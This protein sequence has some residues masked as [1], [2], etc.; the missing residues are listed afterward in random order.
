MTKESGGFFRKVAKFVANPTTDWA[1]LD[2]A[3]TSPGESEFAKSEIKAMIE[4]KRR[5]DF[6][7]KRE[8]D[9]LRKI[10]REGLT[11]DAALALGSPSNLDPESSPHAGARSDMAVKAKIDAIEQQMVG[12]VT[13]QPV[14]TP[15]ARPGTQSIRL[16]DMPTQ[17]DAV[18]S[19]ATLPF[20][21][22]PAPQVS[23]AVLDAAREALPG[24]HARAMQPPT[25]DATTDVVEVMH[26]PEL[27]E[28]VIAFANA[29]FDQ[30]ERDLMALVQPG[31]PRHDHLDT[32]MVLFDLYRALDLPQKFEQLAVSFVQKFGVSPPQWYSLP[33]KVSQFLNQSQSGAAPAGDDPAAPPPDDVIAREGWLAPTVLDADAMA[34]LRIACLQLPRPWTMSWEAVEDIRP[35]GAAL[36]AQAMNQWAVDG[37]ALVWH[38]AELLLERLAEL[39]PTGSRDADPAYWMLKL[40]ILRLTNRP[41]LFDEVAIDYCVTY[42]LSPPSWE[43]SLARVLV[44]EDTVSA[45]TRPLSHVSEVTTSFVESQMLDDVE[46]VQVA[47]LNLSGQLLG[48]IGDTL[49]RLDDQ[50]GASVTL[51]IDCQHLLRVDFIAAGDLLNW[52]LVRRTEGREVH[53]MQPHRL[54]AL[55]FGAMGINEH[56]RVKLQHV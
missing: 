39:S 56:A 17:P 3:R 53:L 18:T 6:V 41:A 29:D 47:T 55:F 19:P 11:P 24:T 35:E 28:A 5:N 33:D 10:R 21:M 51:E 25:L 22:T 26:D 52:V 8:L 32:W 45:P 2:R 49:A 13:R 42:E 27:D 40:A 12:V 4:R 38:G 23:Q 34:A 14:E 15:V 37:Q 20:E 46:F 48:D 7:R 30:C 31:A 36:L 1:E 50:L 44:T 9:M 16:H 54:V 43:P